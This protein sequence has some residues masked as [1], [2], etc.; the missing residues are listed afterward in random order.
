MKKT[1]VLCLLLVFSLCF[2]ACEFASSEPHILKLETPEKIAEV[3]YANE[4][5]FQAAVEAIT[6]AAEAITEY[7]QEG[8]IYLTIDDISSSSK[9]HTVKEIEGLFIETKDPLL[10]S[11]Y[12]SLYEAFAPMM[13]NGICNGAFKRG[14]KVGFVLEGPT[15]GLAAYLYYIQDTDFAAYLMQQTADHIPWNRYER[16]DSYWYSYI[17][18]D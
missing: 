3:Y 7:D 5:D 10:E 13:D 9:F 8:F 1:A 15:L 2:T 14:S 4:E 16:I 12:Q 6:E 11:S 17:W 18:S